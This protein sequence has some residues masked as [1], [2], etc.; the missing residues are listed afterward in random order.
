M[1]YLLCIS[2]I[3]LHAEPALTESDVEL[4]ADGFIF[5]EGPIWI[6]ASDTLLFSDIP[7][8][9]IY[10]PDKTV[11]RKPSGQSNGLT[12]DSK[13]RLI[14]C[15][16]KNR[17]V[18]RT[19]KNGDITV[20]ADKYEGKRLNSP[21]DII[22]RSDGVIFFTDPP[23]GLPGGLEGPNAELTF[24]GVYRLDAD[25][26]ITLLKDD[27]IKPNGLALSPDE[28]TLY[29]ADT[30]GKHIRVFD[31]TANGEL[32]NDRIFCELG[33]PDGIKVDTKGNVWSTS[34]DGMRIYNP[35]GKLLQIIPCSQ[36]PANCAFGDK[37]SRT[38]YITAR[39]GVYKV[40]TT[41][42]GIRPKLKTK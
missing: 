14:A 18:T 7:A 30:E 37:D 21:N 12:L 32:K 22:L 15:E 6:D 20:L 39:T 16:H 31:V 29:I 41:I 26:K 10:E 19:E 42:A 33:G 40:R 36:T 24:A 34:A 35:A 1:M 8:D 13:G 17:R 11:F 9:T 27:F 25:G 5:T 3:M 4:V 2:S 28:K 23:Y 38:L